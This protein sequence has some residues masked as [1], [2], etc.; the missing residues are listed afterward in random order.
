MKKKEFAIIR[1]DGKDHLCY[2]DDNQYVDVRMPML[3]FTEGEDKFGI[4]PPNPSFQTKT[5]TYNRHKVFVRPEMYPNKWLAI[6]VVDSED[7]DNYE[8]L[9]VNLETMPAIGLPDSAFVDCNNQP[10]A[11]KFLTNN[12]FA[13]DSGYKRRSGFVQYPLVNLN[14]VLL[15]QHAPQVFQEAS[16]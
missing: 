15:Y 3:T 9:T 2:K 10:D 6:S 16:I 4:I 13:S 12:R 7:P 1:F 8:V 14:L 5:Y 11:L